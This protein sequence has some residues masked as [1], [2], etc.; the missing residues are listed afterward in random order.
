MYTGDLSTHTYRDSW[1]RMKVAHG[2]GPCL[3]IY[4]F[5]CLVLAMLGLHCCTGFSL[6]VELLIAGASLVVEH[7]LWACGLH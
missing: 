4:Y 7:R 5:I 3:N 6:V 2:E 1:L